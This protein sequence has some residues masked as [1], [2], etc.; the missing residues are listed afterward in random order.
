MHS[1]W[2]LNLLIK[3]RSRKLGDIGLKS[4]EQKRSL[5]LFSLIQAKSVA[6]A[7]IM[8]CMGAG[9]QKSMTMAFKKDIRKEIFAST[10]L[11]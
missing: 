2:G 6:R 1:D 5:I 11:Q 8:H 7:S 3:G 9:S 4:Q 10:S